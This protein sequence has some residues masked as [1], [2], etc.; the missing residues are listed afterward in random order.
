MQPTRWKGLAYSQEQ[1]PDLGKVNNIPETRRKESH[2][3]HL[4]QGYIPSII[5]LMNKV[6][7][8]GLY[9]TLNK[10][11]LCQLVVWFER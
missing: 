7:K 6:L 1:D 11:D 10:P 2:L 4:Y 9:N 3:S 5:E 8:M